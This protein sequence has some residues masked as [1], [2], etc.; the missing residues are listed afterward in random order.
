MELEL[1]I[2]CSARVWMLLKAKTNE[3]ALA[4]W[5]TG[6]MVPCPAMCQDRI[7]DFKMMGPEEQ[8]RGLSDGL[9]DRWAGRMRP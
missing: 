7:E 9:R 2:V 8:P 5:S 4:V 6:W 3:L 1:R